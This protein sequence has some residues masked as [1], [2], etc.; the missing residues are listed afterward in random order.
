MIKLSRWS[1][2]DLNDQAELSRWS[3]RDLNDQIELSIWSSCDLNDQTELSI[4]YS[5]CI[6]ES[7]WYGFPYQSN[8]EL[9]LLHQ[10]S[11]K[12]LT[13]IISLFWIAILSLEIFTGGSPVKICTV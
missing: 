13:K 12:I 9:V 1:S 7:T 2:S 4:W 5:Q 11:F 6:G 3:S 8:Y 10:D